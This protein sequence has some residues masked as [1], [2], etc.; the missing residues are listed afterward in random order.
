MSGL[1]DNPHF[2]EGKFVACCQ[3]SQLIL[4]RFLYSVVGTWKQCA[5]LSAVCLRQV[6]THRVI[7]GE[8]YVQITQCVLWQFP[9]CT[10]LDSALPPARKCRLWCCRAGNIRLRVLVD[11]KEVRITF[12]LLMFI[13]CVSHVSIQKKKIKSK[14]LLSANELVCWSLRKASVTSLFL[15]PFSS[16]EVFNIL[17]ALSAAIL[18]L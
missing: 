5:K 12:D 11:S 7:K 1:S 18:H 16:R 2:F 17:F 8:S 6:S 9:K 4:D 3:I 15:K 10:T 13:L 14:Y